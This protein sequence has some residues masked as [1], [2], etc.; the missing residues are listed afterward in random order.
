MTLFQKLILAFIIILVA[1]NIFYESG[2]NTSERLLNKSTWTKFSKD[3]EWAKL[4]SLEFKPYLVKVSPRL[5]NWKFGWQFVY[6]LETR[7]LRTDTLLSKK[8][9]TDFRPFSKAD[10]WWLSNDKYGLHHLENMI[11][12][13]N[14]GA[15]FYNSKMPEYAFLN[16]TKLS[17]ITSFLPPK[18]IRI[19]TSDNHS[20]MIR[21]N[22][23][24]IFQ[25]D[26]FNAFFWVAT[27]LLSLFVGFSG[28]GTYFVPMLA[29]GFASIGLD[30][31]IWYFLVFVFIFSVIMTIKMEG[32]AFSGLIDLTIEKPL[33]SKVLGIAIYALIVGYL[34]NWKLPSTLNFAVFLPFI[35]ALFIEFAALLILFLSA[36]LFHTLYLYFKY[37]KQ[38]ISTISFSNI[39][40]NFDKDSRETGKRIPMF[41][42]DI[43]LNNVIKIKQANV[44]MV[45]YKRLKKGKQVS[46]RYFKTDDKGN[47]LFTN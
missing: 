6:L 23:L 29:L 31:S 16:E 4:G 3:E 26:T 2:T 36:N 10:V 35:F 20:L 43:L 34:F 42:A 12:I 22:P 8:I 5:E 41:Y 15:E 46:V 21:S 44:S 40:S 39:S 27:S 24:L 25:E 37:K 38:L 1:I 7:Y 19:T 18:A 11:T 33:L 32:T 30:F 9:K 14:D 13:D 28:R 17:F 47:Y 45:I